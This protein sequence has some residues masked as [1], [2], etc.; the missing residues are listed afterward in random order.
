MEVVQKS[1]GK[2]HFKKLIIANCLPNADYAQ[3]ASLAF[4]V[5]PGISTE[6]L[7]EV[8]Q[9]ILEIMWRA[10]KTRLGKNNLA[11]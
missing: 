11:A 9:A 6:K 5:H 3:R 2:S 10:T 4:L 1:T 8:V 7:E